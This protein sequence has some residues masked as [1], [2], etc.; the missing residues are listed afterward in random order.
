[1][2][3]LNLERNEESMEPSR[4]TPLAHYARGLRRS[5]GAARLRMRIL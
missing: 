5:F 4:K 2:I 3:A 1:M